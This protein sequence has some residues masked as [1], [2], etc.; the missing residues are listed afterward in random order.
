MHLQLRNLIPAT[1]EHNSKMKELYNYDPYAILPKSISARR[2]NGLWH[3]I[4]SPVLSN[5]NDFLEDVRCVMG[6]GARIDFWMDIK[7]HDKNIEFG[8]WVNG[9]WIWRIELRR[10]LFSWKIPIWDQFNQFFS[11]VGFWAK[12]LWPSLVSH[13]LDF[14]S[15]C[16]VCRFSPFLV[17]EFH[18][19]TG[20]SIL[21]KCRF[22]WYWA[23]W[24]DFS[25]SFHGLCFC[26]CSRLVDPSAFWVLLPLDA[27]QDSA[28]FDLFDRMLAL[29][30]ALLLSFLLLWFCCSI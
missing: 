24:Y 2:Y 25:S 21:C 14:H 9:I 7:K 18:L 29:L 6:N 30:I 15:S 11:E 1:S 28:P 4:V 3:V 22:L 10:G 26:Y 17:S 8:S 13:V 12:F 5:E 16:S 27:L 20:S 23:S 19:D